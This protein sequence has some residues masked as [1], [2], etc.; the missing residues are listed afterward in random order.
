MYI[1]IQGIHTK[2]ENIYI[3]HNIIYKTKSVIEITT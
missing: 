1:K 2:N 3:N